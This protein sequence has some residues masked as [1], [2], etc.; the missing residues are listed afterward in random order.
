MN[1]EKTKEVTIFYPQKD[2][3]LKP[4]SILKLKK[5]NTYL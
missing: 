2:C 5:C 4:A 3:A 1:K